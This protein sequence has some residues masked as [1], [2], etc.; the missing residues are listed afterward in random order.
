MV[1][2]PISL[3]HLSNIPFPLNRNP[4]VILFP[5]LLIQNLN[6]W[7]EKIVFSC[8]NNMGLDDL[9]SILG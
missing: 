5:C 3:F 4:K 8:S 1:L 9:I 6:P 2:K 7:L